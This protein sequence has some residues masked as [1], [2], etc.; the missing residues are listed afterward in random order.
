[1]TEKDTRT[2][3]E[4]ERDRLRRDSYETTERLKGQLKGATR[5]LW[6]GLCGRCA[7]LELMVTDSEV[8][9]ARCGEFS[10]RLDSRD[11]VKECTGYWPRGHPTLSELIDRARLI[12]VPTFT[13]GE[14]GAGVY[15]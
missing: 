13:K 15:L 6:P 14:P 1:M 9:R 3:E 4:Q 10:Q 8:K 11:P 7:H 2:P 5:A 12:H